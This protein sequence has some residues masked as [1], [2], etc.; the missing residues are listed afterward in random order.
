MKTL[1]RLFAPAGLVARFT[2]YAAADTVWH[3]DASFSYNALANTATGTFE[4]DP[5]NDVVTWDITVSEPMLRPTTYTRRAT[6]SIF[7]RI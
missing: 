5:S 3:L 4:L 6:A 1:I 2:S 7:S